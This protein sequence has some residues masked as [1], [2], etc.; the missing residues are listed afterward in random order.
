VVSFT[1]RPLYPRRKYLL[2][3]KLGGPQSRSTRSERREKFT[4]PPG[5][6][7][8]IVQP[9]ASR[10]TDYLY[11]CIII[12][13]I[14]VVVVVVV[15]VVVIIIIIIIII[16]LSLRTEHRASIV[17]RH[18]RILFQF[19]GSTRHLVGLLEGGISPAQGLYLHRT[20]QHRKTQTNIHV[21]MFERPKTVLAL[22]RSAIET[23][24]QRIR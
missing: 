17:P 11:H 4:A 8:P 21:P 15:V 20:I 7:T 18:P 3:R 23:G 9:V 2:D 19:L 16:P 12:I 10:Y 24:F 13:I 22:D 1:P 6:E 14:I 5:I